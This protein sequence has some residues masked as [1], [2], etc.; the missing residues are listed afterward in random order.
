MSVW[1]TWPALTKLGTLGVVSG[2]L[3]LAVERQALFENNLFDVE[4]YA[5]YHPHHPF[6]SPTPPSTGSPSEFGP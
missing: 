1:V 4:K 5:R 3:V 2:L 6:H